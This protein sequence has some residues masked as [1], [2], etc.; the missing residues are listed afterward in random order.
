MPTEKNIILALCTAN[1]C[2]SQMFEAILKHYAKDRYTVLSAGTRATFVHPLAVKVL[3]EIGISAEGQTSKK[4]LSLDPV[5]DKLIL[6]D[7]DQQRLEFPLSRITRVITLCGGANESCP[8]FPGSAVREHW[9]I[10]DPDQYTGTEAEVLPYF[11]ATRDDIVSRVKDF[12]RGSL[13]S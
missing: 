9:P 3:E 4:I 2:R 11:R 13:H 10:D 1:R 5:Q 12:Q 8:I 7:Q 6:E